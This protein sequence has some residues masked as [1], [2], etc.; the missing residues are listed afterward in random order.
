MLGPIVECG[1]V[2][3]R[4]IGPGESVHLGIER[5][6]VEDREVAQESIQLPLKNRAKI[7]HPGESIG[8]LDVQPVRPDDAK[9]GH[10]VKPFPR[11]RPGHE[12]NPVDR[13]DPNR[14][15]VLGVEVWSMMRARRL[16]KHPNDDPEEPSQFRHA[17]QPLLRAEPRWCPF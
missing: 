7:D 2:E 13:D 9:G 3:I 8:E 6:L 4:A 12:F 11:E 17:P 15:L 14:V 10:L 16:G 5:D 1:G